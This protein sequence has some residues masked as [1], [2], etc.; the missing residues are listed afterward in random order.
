MRIRGSQRLA[1][2]FEVRAGVVGGPVQPVQNLLGAELDERWR[3][4]TNREL[5]GEGFER[6]P[7]SLFSCFVLSL[8][9]YSIAAR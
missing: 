5:L 7:R 8:S 3:S 2:P 4:S 6:T 9:W 1:V